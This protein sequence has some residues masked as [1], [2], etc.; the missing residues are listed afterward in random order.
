M[1]YV[2]GS[3]PAGVSCAAGLLARGYAVTML[4]AGIELEEDKQAVLE[5]LQFS[6]DDDLLKSLKQKLNTKDPIKLSHNSFY[7]Y[8]EVASHFSL[9]A[10][11]SIHCLP[12]FA[13]GGLSNVWGAFVEKYTETELNSWPISYSQ[14]APHYDAILKFLNPALAR[15]QIEKQNCI[16]NSYNLSRQAQL[17]LNEMEKNADCLNVEGFLFATSQLAVK[18]N[19]AQQALCKECAACQHGCPLDLIY[20]AR[21]TLKELLKNSKFRYIKNIIVKNIA[22]FEDKVLISAVNRSNDATVNFEGAQV[23]SACGPVISTALVLKACQAFDEKIEFLDSTHFM[24]PCI[25]KKRVKNVHRENLHTLSHLYLKYENAKIQGKP[26]N[27]QIYTYMDHYTEKFKHLLKGFYPIAV[28]FLRPIIDRMIVI[29]AHLHSDHSHKFSLQ[30]EANGE[31]KLQALRNEET[32]RVI[33]RVASD[34]QKNHRSLGF[35]PVNAMLSESKICK[36]FHYGGS[37]PMRTKPGKFETDVL[38]RPQGFKRWH[39]VDAS[40]FPSIPAG[41]ITPTIMAN[42]YRISMESEIY[43]NL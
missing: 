23:F 29:Q 3:G 24:L 10:E 36:S 20:S 26:I 43:A 2:I 34:L 13:Q 4:D 12:S 41:S 9:N 8:T 6:W 28:P 42:A 31:L 19:H 5:R 15:E 37:M 22:E 30:L 17:L 39:V 18:F 25:M 40:V 21:N 7:P 14:L 35:I 27:L 16:R 38:G 11:N 32:S 33:K 1:I